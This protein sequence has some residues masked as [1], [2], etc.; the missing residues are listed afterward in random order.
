MTRK[1]SV[2]ILF[3]YAG[4]K[5]LLRIITVLQA[6]VPIHARIVKWN[7]IVTWHVCCFSNKPCR[8]VSSNFQ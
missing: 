2:N 6:I 5:I 4:V 1:H 8:V 3:F 7:N